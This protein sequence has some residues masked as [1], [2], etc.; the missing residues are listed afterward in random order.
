MKIVR[1]Y[2]RLIDSP[3]DASPLAKIERCGRVSHR[4]EESQTQE[5]WRGFLQRVVLQHGDWSIVEHVS[6]SV[7]MVVDRGVT[8]ELVRHRLFSYTQESTRFVRYFKEKDGDIIQPASF[9][10]P[11]VDVECS[12]CLAGET[13]DLYADTDDGR[14]EHAGPKPCPYDPRWLSAISS[15][16][17]TYKRLLKNG[18]RPQEARSVL[19]NA[20]ASR[21]VTTGNLRV[22]RHLF[23][24]RTTKETHPQFKQVTIPLL[25]EFQKAFPVL[26]D[27]IVPGARQIDNLRLP[28]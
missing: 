4:T 19:P 5:S 20:L 12:L 23:I 27:D 11:Q 2:A 26:F 10:Y 16:E 14:A 22:W 17:D 1:P 28:Q 7:D 25:A 18:W 15:A 9:I 3:V 8:H 13:P 21:I 6:A 24:M